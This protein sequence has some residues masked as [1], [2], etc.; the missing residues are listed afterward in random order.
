MNTIKPGYQTT[1]FWIS[2]VVTLASALVAVLPTDNTVAK[3][4]ALVVAVAAQLGYVAGRVSV[5]NNLSQ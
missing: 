2:L 3:V 5:K 4:A 1:E